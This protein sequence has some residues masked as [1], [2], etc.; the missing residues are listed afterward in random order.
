MQ[1]CIPV[2][3]AGQAVTSVSLLSLHKSD[4]RLLQTAAKLGQLMAEAGQA[5]AE[6]MQAEAEEEEAQQTSTSGDPIP[7]PPFDIHSC[8]F[9]SCA[10]LLQLLVS[11]QLARPTWLCVTSSPG[12]KPFIVAC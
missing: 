11:N 3:V 6:A 9:K 12:R 8:K 1:V 5:I 2:E 4:M 7:L 10:M